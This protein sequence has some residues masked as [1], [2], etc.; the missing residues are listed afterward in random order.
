VVTSVFGSVAWLLWRAKLRRDSADPERLPTTSDPEP[1]TTETITEIEQPVDVSST[2]GLGGTKGLESRQTQLRQSQEELTALRGAI[3]VESQSQPDV[4]AET[5]AESEIG[6]KPDEVRPSAS[7]KE[8]Q[9][10]L[11]AHT[12]PPP[13]PSLPSIER[14]SEKHGLADQAD[15]SNADDRNSGSHLRAPT[16]TVT[17]ID[18]QNSDDAFGG[19]GI[20]G[21]IVEISNDEDSHADI[22]IAEELPS[23]LTNK[24]TREKTETVPRHHKLPSQKPKPEREATTGPDTQTLRPADSSEVLPG[25]GT[26]DEAD[27]T[28]VDDRHSPSHLTA[29]TTTAT[30]IDDPN[31]DDA[32]AETGIAGESAEVSND[33]D[34][35][36]DVNIEEE[37][38][39]SPMDQPVSEKI[40]RIPRRYRPPSQRPARNATTRAVNQTLRSADSSEV[41]LRILVHLTFDRFGCLK[42]VS[43]RSV[44]RVWMKK[45]W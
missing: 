24:A 27:V 25:I 19:I 44:H 28:N 37:P 32:Y 7:G 23:S 30:P 42:S 9:G 12:E 31:P 35:Q 16:N 20:A 33:E 40:A 2:D 10:E 8:L 39:P 43:Y 18:D 3:S 13:V 17:P 5:D 34:S 4:L 41:L 36:A 22:N 6:E 1:N 29:S 38:P 11:I 15:V 45:L 21:E 14:A 26:T